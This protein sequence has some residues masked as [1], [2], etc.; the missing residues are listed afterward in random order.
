MFT[1]SLLQSIF[2][3]HYE[4]ILYTMH[5]RR[6]EIEN[7]E[8]MIQCG[9]ERY[10]YAWYECKS[11][12]TVKMVPFHCKSRFCPSCGVKYA[13]QRSFTFSKKMLNVKHRHIVFT[14]DEN[15]RP[16][17]L[18]DR[19]LLN[20]LFQA[21]KDVLFRFFFKQNKSELFTPGFV[22][23]L[24][25]FGRDLK[26][27]PHIHC[28]CT[29]GGAGN[30]IVWRKLSHFDFT[31]LRKSFQKVLLER[32][33]AKIGPSFKPVLAKSYKDHTNGF[34]VYAKDSDVSTSEMMKYISRYLGRPVI[35]NS[36]IDK[37]DGD[38]VTFHYNRHE[39]EKY[40]EETVP[41]LDFIKRLIIHI[42]EK[43][44]RMVRY[45]G[46]YAK[47]HKQEPNLHKF[48]KNLSNPK[49]KKL[50]EGWFKWRALILSCFK[51]DPI[52]CPQ[53]RKTMTLMLIRF[54]NGKETMIEHYARIMGK[55]P[56]WRPA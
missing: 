51:V 29:E 9:D 44:F 8:R 33:L 36:R 55:P 54:R 2:L 39:D 35:A 17:F 6:T 56:D 22:S 30:L 14:I 26:W 42:P 24:H 12:N 27:N 49:Y 40:I 11:C 47:H 32:L 45:Y 52:E 10:G 48:N 28:V 16:F 21:V 41:V 23:V 43:S 38:F 15:L 20:E 34:Y 25:T 18:Q 37:Y 7:I 31:F 50:F 3:D 4:E 1:P 46:L 53:C 19:S 13:Y 5:P